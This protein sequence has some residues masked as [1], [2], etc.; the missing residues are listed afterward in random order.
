MRFLYG[1]I[2]LLQMQFF[3]KLSKYLQ[4]TI[5][6]LWNAAIDD[7]IKCQQISVQVFRSRIRGF[8]GLLD[9]DPVPDPG[10]IC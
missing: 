1:G 9:P 6:Q 10:L 5:W 4:Y 3:H 2:S 8:F 7:M